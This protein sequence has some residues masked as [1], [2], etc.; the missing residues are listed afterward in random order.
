[1]PTQKINLIE[2]VIALLEASNHPNPT[3]W[4][5]GIDA[6]A[7][8]RLP[9]PVQCSIVTNPL[10]S[11]VGPFL[12]EISLVLEKKAG[13]EEWLQKFKVHIASLMANHNL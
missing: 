10:Y 9:Y 5:K 7:I 11:I 12:P 2:D 1:M 13:Y 6:A 3:K 8:S 4:L